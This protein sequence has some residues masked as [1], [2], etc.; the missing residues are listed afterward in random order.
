MF[1]LY[2]L[3]ILITSKPVSICFSMDVN[4]HFLLLFKSCLEAISRWQQLIQKHC[5]D[6]TCYMYLHEVYYARVLL[7]PV[8]FKLQASRRPRTQ[9]IN[10]RPQIGKVWCVRRPCL[11][12]FSPYSLTGGSSCTVVPIRTTPLGPYT[13][14]EVFNNKGMTVG[15]AVTCSIWIQGFSG[16]K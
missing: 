7:W 6:I 5:D 13:A 4:L 11:F 16:T 14:E 12:L 3:Q 10:V 2:H 1:V 9:W 15:I 8:D